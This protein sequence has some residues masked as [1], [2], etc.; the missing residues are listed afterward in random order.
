MRD[1]IV[2]LR[3]TL[4]TVPNVPC[5]FT[6][7]RSGSRASTNSLRP[8]EPV[9]VLGHRARQGLYDEDRVTDDVIGAERRNRVY[10]FRAFHLIHRRLP[11]ASN[12]RSL[13]P[14]TATIR[15]NDDAR[16]R[17]GYLAARRFRI[18]VALAA[19]APPS[20]SRR[21]HGRALCMPR[22]RVWSSPW[23]RQSGSTSLS[24]R[25]QSVSG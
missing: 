24:R 20:V 21:R 7:I 14:I 10:V 16:I 25:R 23:A 17:L 4:P 6:A 3:E 9:V 22:S 13:D 18:F 19:I 15:E 5:K 1:T 2:R 8:F 12:N 11:A